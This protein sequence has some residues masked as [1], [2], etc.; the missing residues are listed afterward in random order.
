MV[1]TRLYVSFQWFQSN[2]PAF[3]IESKTKV[4]QKVSAQNSVL[5]EPGRFIYRLQ[6]ENGRTDPLPCKTAQA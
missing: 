2:Q 3:E 1:S 4:T 6:I 5:R